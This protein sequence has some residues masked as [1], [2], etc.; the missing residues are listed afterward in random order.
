MLDGPWAGTAVLYPGRCAAELNRVSLAPFLFQCEIFQL[1]A[2][3]VAHQ[4]TLSQRRSGSSEMDR[5]R[6]HRAGWRGAGWRV[7]PTWGTQR[8]RE[9]MGWRNAPPW[10][11]ARLATKRSLQRSLLL[12]DVH[13]P[14]CRS[15][16]PW[17]EARRGHFG[18]LPGHPCQ[19]R[20]SGCEIGRRESLGRAATWCAAATATPDGIPHILLKFLAV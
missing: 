3:R 11:R 8:G 4:R 1:I 5:G 2:R 12:W 18:G 15:I 17:S 14:I 19:V 16:A 7:Q 13:W 10:A 9:R 6:N 20:G